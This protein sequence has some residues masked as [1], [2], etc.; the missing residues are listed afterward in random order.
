M[1][2]LVIFAALLAMFAAGAVFGEC[3][4]MVK[5]SIAIDGDKITVILDG[6]AWEHFAE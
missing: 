2:K 3:R 5:S 1:K 6:H 4:A